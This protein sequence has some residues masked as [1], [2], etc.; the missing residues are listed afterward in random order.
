M[1]Y[2]KNDIVSVNGEGRYKI[3]KCIENQYTKYL[4][5]DIYKGEG[6]DETE[7]K[8]VGVFV[9]YGGY[10]NGKYVGSSWYRGENEFIGT[11][12]TIHRNK[13]TLIYR[14]IED[15]EGEDLHW[16]FEHLNIQ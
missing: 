5:E 9:N 12:E 10:K 11:V 3:I 13:L 8:F 6:W 2:L 4:I 14:P 16:M 15:L 7:Q 1:N